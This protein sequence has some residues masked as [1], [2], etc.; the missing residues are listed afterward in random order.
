VAAGLASAAAPVALAL[1]EVSVLLGGQTVLREVS[2]D[3]AAGAHVAVVGASGAGKSTLIGLLLGFHPAA[4]GT[5]RLDGQ[6]A[7][8]ATLVQLR[9]QVAWVDP[10]VRLWNRS[11]FDNLHNGHAEGRAD[12]LSQAMATA[13]L[14]RVIAR[15][16]AGLAT[17]LG[18]GGRLVS[19]GEGQR[20]RLGRTLVQPAPRL[21]L[22][23]EPFR[24]LDRGQR[25][26][27][28]ARVRSTWAETTLLLVTHDIASTLSFPRVLVIEDGRLIE[29]GEPGE[30]R[31]RPDSRYAALLRAEQA[32]RRDLWAA[33]GWERLSMV[34]GR[35]SAQ[36]E[37]DAMPEEP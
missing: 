37:Q 29:A 24:G 7:D 2:L 8:Q 32:V 28:L 6:P 30:L 27:L 13:D 16:P 21:V 20:V 1:S 12:R 25:Q 3:I 19:G 35:L 22:L 4:S 34:D 33:G 18:E 14:R 23:D 15:L 31:A 26:E 10:D 17:P 9:P 11:L 36:P 5:V